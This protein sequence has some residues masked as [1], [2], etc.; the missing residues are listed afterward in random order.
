MIIFLGLAGSG[1]STQGQILAKKHGWQWISAG[2]VLRESGNFDKRIQQ[3]ELADIDVVTRLMGD[4]FDEAQQ[5]GKKIILDGFPRSEEQA[6]WLVD[7]YLDDVEL[8]IY[9]EV[10]REEVSERM[11]RR[12]RI[13]DTPEAIQRRIEIA[14]QNIY[15]I[16]SLLR[17][18]NIRI[19]NIDGTGSIAEVTARLEKAIDEQK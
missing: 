10:L 2:Q 5:A 15:S 3:G 19:E 11:L 18:H 9:M 1:K 6:Q 12:G 13:D 7:N 8:V 17:E 16:L 14:E 4:K